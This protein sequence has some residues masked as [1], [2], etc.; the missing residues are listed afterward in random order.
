MLLSLLVWALWP[1]A[2]NANFSPAVTGAGALKPDKDKIDLGDVH[3][4]NTVSASFQVT[5][6][7]SKPLHFTK[8]PYIQVVEGC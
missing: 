8:A 6:V 7:G 2:T 5:N 1:P 4:G 3:L